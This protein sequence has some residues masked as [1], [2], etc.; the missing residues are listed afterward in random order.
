MAVTIEATKGANDANSYATITEADTFFNT[1]YGA[2]EWDGL[3]DDDKARLLITATLFLED[4]PMLYDKFDA[5]Q[6]LNFPVS[7]EG[8]ESGFANATRA[9]LYQAY[10]LFENMDALKEAQSGAI[11]GIKSEGLSSIS[12]SV[13]G[14]NALKRWA[15][16]ALR[17]LS[18][19]TNFDLTVTKNATLP[20]NGT[21]VAFDTNLGRLF[22][23]P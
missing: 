22:P 1:L 8:V 16:G 19:Y 10:Y 11:S 18:G 20:Y 9:C 4:L 3:S 6:S 14:F 17:C 23:R 5:A 21:T 7:I 15:S 12:K 13:T 2:S